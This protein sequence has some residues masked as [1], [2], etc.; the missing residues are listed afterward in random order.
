VSIPDDKIE[1]YLKF[2]FD[3]VLPGQVLHHLLVA[4]ADPAGDGALGL[5][6][7]EAVTVSVYAMVLDK[8]GTM[9]ID[10]LI[11]RTIVRA[12][13]DA[14]RAG[15]VVHFAGLATETH[16]V[17]TY[18]ERSR[19]AAA[20]LLA[21]RRLQEHPDAVEAVWLYA[22]CRDGRRWSGRRFVTGPRAGTVWG[23]DPQTG[24]LADH[25]RGSYERLIQAVVG[26]RL[27]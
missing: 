16:A 25:E 5:P 20:R 1:G 9:T 4:T 17:V 15:R 10:Q 13:L 26:L 12:G 14:Q 19:E 8:E 22:A 27:G 11:E 18:D 23:P 3:Q 6:D 7:P 24:A 21:G 2:L